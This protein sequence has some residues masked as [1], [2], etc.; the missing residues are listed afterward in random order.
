MESFTTTIFLAVSECKKLVINTV[1]I[2]ETR[3]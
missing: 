3:S 1:P 2:T